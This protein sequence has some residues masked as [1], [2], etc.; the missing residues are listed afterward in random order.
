MGTA[1]ASSAGGIAAHLLKLRASFQFS[2]VFEFSYVFYSDGI[3][4]ANAC[5]A[6][7]IDVVIQ[8]I[9]DYGNLL[10][11]GKLRALVTMGG[12]QLTVEGLAQPIPPIRETL[13]TF[14]IRENYFGF[15]LPPGTPTNVVQA[16][17]AVWDE[18]IPESPELQAY[19]LRYG[20]PYA[21]IFGTVA[22]AT[23]ASYVAY[24]AWGLHLT[25]FVPVSPTVFGIRKP[26]GPGIH[27]M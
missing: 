18:V 15:F 14:S 6:G 13:P 10:R 27:Y 17:Q 9:P 4:A 8:S 7:E 23:V 12:E 19:A 21:P 1:G 24:A 16:V 25:G 20:S 5:A 11:E 22:K 26:G 3:Q 2:N